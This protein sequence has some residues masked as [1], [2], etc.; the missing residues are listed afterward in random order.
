MHQALEIPE[1][2]NSICRYMIT[3]DRSSL[4][5]IGRTSHALN[6]SAMPVLWESLGSIVPLIKL[7]PKDAIFV[8]VSQDGYL[9]KCTIVSSS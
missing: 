8:R 3:D 2:V 6:A 9:I 4:A 7:L 5:R 1:L